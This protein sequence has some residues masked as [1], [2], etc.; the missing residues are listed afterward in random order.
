MHRKIIDKL[1][2]IACE[3]IANVGMGR[4]FFSGGR[5]SSDPACA[6]AAQPDRSMTLRARLSAGMLCRVMRHEACNVPWS[7]TARSAIR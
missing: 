7:T 4:L 3:H 2:S 6:C 5:G 1:I